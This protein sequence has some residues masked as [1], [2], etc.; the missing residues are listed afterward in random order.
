MAQTFNNGDVDLNRYLDDGPAITKVKPASSFREQLHAKFRAEND[1]QWGQLPFKKTLDQVRLRPGDLS[2][3]AG[4][5]GDGK[6]AFLSQTILGLMGASPLRACIAS[7]EMEPA[8]TL[9]RM[10]MQA[11][12]LAHP[13]GEYLDAFSK[14]TD[15]KLWIYDHLG[16][17]HWKQVVALMRYLHQELGIQHAV[18]DSFTK[19]GIAP[20]D[21]TAQKRFTD[22]LF[23]HCK[24]TG[25][26]IHL[27]CHMRKPEKQGYSRRPSKHDVRGAGEITDM[28]DNLFMVVRNRA[29]EDARADEDP[30]V[31]AKV[32]REPD[33]FLFIE[34]QRNH[35]FEG[36]IGLWFFPTLR[37]WVE[38]GVDQAVP[39][40]L[41]I[42][43]VQETLAG[44]DF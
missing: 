40:E 17:V 15:D 13:A 5:N 4:A 31:G 18:I 16:T 37:R 42:E 33:T 30:K 14:W 3:W 25:M 27:V 38:N 32:M 26:H 44:V 7:L 21:L 9:K 23:A 20:D 19:C 43:R 12:A 1:R 36:Q 8:E 24:A 41:G 2:I 22:E 35:S 39:M 10:T 11:S 28:A 34:K 6:S 29:K